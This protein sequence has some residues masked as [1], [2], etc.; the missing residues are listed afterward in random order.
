[1]SNLE[2]RLLIVAVLAVV[3]GAIADTAQAQCNNDCRMKYMHKYDT[4]E[5]I[6]IS[7]LNCIFCQPGLNVRCRDLGPYGG[8]CTQGTGTQLIY[9][10]AKCD[11]QCTGAHAV[12]EANN[13]TDKQTGAGST[14]HFYCK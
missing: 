8:T 13:M 5:C 3:C 2:I 9:Y 10:F 1:M 4:G 12:V 7:G 6:T 11:P 14:P